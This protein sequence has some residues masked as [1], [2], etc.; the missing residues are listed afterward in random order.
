[1]HLL[2]GPRYVHTQCTGMI[3]NFTEKA[4]NVCPTLWLRNCWHRY[5]TKILHYTSLP[6]HVAVRCALILCTF[7]NALV[8]N[9]FVYCR[10]SVCVITPSPLGERSKY[11]PYL[12]LLTVQAMWAKTS[13]PKR[14]ADTDRDGMRNGRRLSIVVCSP[15]SV[16][17]D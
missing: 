10:T 5:V 1:M 9:N 12:A 2:H 8:L 16:T 14:R 7:D 17:D 13:Q 11:I 3:I 6:S 15:S 4:I